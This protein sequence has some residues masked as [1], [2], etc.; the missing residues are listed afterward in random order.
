MATGTKECV[1]NSRYNMQVNKHGD[2][3]PEACCGVTAAGRVCL[4]CCAGK[5]RHF[6][7]YEKDLNFVTE[8]LPSLSE[9]FPRNLLKNVSDLTASENDLSAPRLLLKLWI[10]LLQ[11]RHV[12]LLAVPNKLRSMQTF[13]KRILHFVSI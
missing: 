1:L 4:L 9:I 2:L 8:A 5:H 11:M 12:D 6:V 10:E 13:L 7:T 3:N